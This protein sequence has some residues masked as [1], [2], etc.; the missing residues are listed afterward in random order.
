M[1]VA[2]SIVS[3]AD[4]ADSVEDLRVSPVFRTSEA[5]SVDLSAREGQANVSMRFRFGGSASSVCS[6]C[7]A[8]GSGTTAFG[9]S[10]A[11]A[12]HANIMQRFLPKVFSTAASPVSGTA[13]VTTLDEGSFLS[14]SDVNGGYRVAGGGGLGV[15]DLGGVEVPSLVSSAVEP[16]LAVL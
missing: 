4:I 3:F 13:G 8:L 2:W 12:L 10:G 5:R 16:M 6:A 7:S 1:V 11:V 9:G 14:M 15:A